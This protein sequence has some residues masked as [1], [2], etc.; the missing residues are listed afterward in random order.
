MAARWDRVAGVSVFG[1][2]AWRNGRCSKRMN[3]LHSSSIVFSFHYSSK[4]P[5]LI[6][7]SEKGVNGCRRKNVPRNVST[8]P[9]R[10]RCCWMDQQAREGGSHAHAVLIPFGWVL[11]LLGFSF[12]WRR[13]VREAQRQASSPPRRAAGPRHCEELAKVRHPTAHARLGWRWPSP[14]SLPS[15][16]PPLPRMASKARAVSCRAVMTQSTSVAGVAK[17]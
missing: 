13:A 3:G 7:E 16:R 1:I 14:S 10:P 6:L 8:Y 17:A 5:V 11:L 2:A 12:G 9:L 15:C 4:H